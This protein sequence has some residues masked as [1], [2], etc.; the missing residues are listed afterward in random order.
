[1]RARIKIGTNIFHDHGCFK[2]PNLMGGGK[3]KH[4]TVFD[5]KKKAGYYDCRADGYGAM[6]SNGIAGKYGSGS[7]FVDN[8]S[9]LV[10]LS[11]GVSDE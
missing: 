4:K 3:A 9:D 2:F 8:L 5:V 7:I 10:V 11:K 1:M 6:P